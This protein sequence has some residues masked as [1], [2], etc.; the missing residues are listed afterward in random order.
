MIV[1]D[2]SLAPPVR[3]HRAPRSVSD[4]LPIPPLG[5]LSSLADNT[6]LPN[7][8]E[9]PLMRFAGP[10]TNHTER[11]QT[12]PN[13]FGISRR[14]FEMPI[15]IPDEDVTLPELTNPIEPPLTGS[16]DKQDDSRSK[17]SRILLDESLSIKDQI[18]SIIYPHPN[19]SAFLM[20]AWFY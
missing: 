11:I 3:R 10:A 7:R 6:W 19:L 20:N 18:L 13:K 14:Y 1:D 8:Q 16:E 12:L 4:H 9:P 5:V 2:D 17:S 15:S